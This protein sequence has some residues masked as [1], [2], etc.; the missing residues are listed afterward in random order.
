MPVYSKIALVSLGIAAATADPAAY[1]RRLGVSSIVSSI[2][3]PFSAGIDALKD[4]PVLTLINAAVDIASTAFGTTTLTVDSDDSR[5]N[6]TVFNTD[7]YL[8]PQ[9]EFFIAG[10][11]KDNGVAMRE[12]YLKGTGAAEIRSGIQRPSGPNTKMLLGYDDV[13]TALQSWEEKITSGDLER[14]NE[15]GIQILNPSLWPEAPGGIKTIGLGQSNPNHAFV[16][17]LLAESLDKGAREG[18]CDGSTCWNDAYLEK[19]A[20]EFFDGREEFQSSDAKW[21][22]TIVL[23]KIHLDLDIDEAAARRFAEYMNKMIILIP[24]TDNILELKIINNVL[25]VKDTQDKKAGYLT[26]FKNAIRKKYADRDFVKNNDVAKIELLASVYL[27]SLQFAGGLSVPTVLG[28]ILALT[29]MAEGN[30]HES[31][32]GQELSMSNYEWIMWETLRKYAPVAGVP[33]WTS[34]KGLNVPDGADWDHI[35]PNVAAAL[36]DATVFENPGEFKNRG[37]RKYH[38]AMMKT[39][40]IENAGMG[41]AGPAIAKN[42][43][44]EFD[45]GAPHSHNCP[46][47]DLSFRLMKAFIREFVKQGP[48]KAANADDVAVSGYKPDNVSLLKKGLKHNTGCSFMPKCRDGFSW[49]KTS[50]CWWGGRDYTCEVL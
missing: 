27:D 6:E 15:L 37:I 17:P 11:Q 42:A 40:D 7:N 14:K 18:S 2:A 8:K 34:R 28:Y 50:W 23:H 9:L 24:L 3:S 36:D 43:N 46:A 45:T 5:F 33:F 41:W 22:T 29:H 39:D 38:E 16:R 35:I 25:S 1:N 4:A 48:W 32:R 31:L 44:G 30:K 49:V 26:T 47:Q 21:W 20:K 10:L 19:M 13:R 12:W